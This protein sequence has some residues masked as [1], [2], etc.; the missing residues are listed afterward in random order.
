MGGFGVT[1]GPLPGYGGLTPS[2]I[3]A[4]YRR[5][6]SSLYYLELQLYYYIVTFSYYCYMIIDN[7]TYNSK[8]MG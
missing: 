2:Q 8:N 3:D 5:G 1:V 6:Y 7:N 4:E